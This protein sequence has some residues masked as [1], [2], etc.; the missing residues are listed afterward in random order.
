LKFICKDQWL[1]R[2]QNIYWHFLLGGSSISHLNTVE[3]PLGYVVCFLNFLLT[4]YL[5]YAGFIT[6][7]PLSKFYF[8][9]IKFRSLFTRLGHTHLFYLRAICPFSWN[10][11]YVLHWRFHD[12]RHMNTSADV[13]QNSNHSSSIL[14]KPLLGGVDGSLHLTVPSMNRFNQTEPA[15]FSVLPS[16][17]FFRNSYFLYFIA[18]ST[19]FV[20]CGG[21]KKSPRTFNKRCYISDP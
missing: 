19:L 14:L 3:S 21:C 8:Y 16:W 18:T 17:A 1:Q 12:N 5:W 2:V 6:S 10:G 11:T 9:F 15:T 13:S 7:D 20:P 4:Y